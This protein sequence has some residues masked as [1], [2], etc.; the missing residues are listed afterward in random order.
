MGVVQTPTIGLSFPSPKNDGNN[1][2]FFNPTSSVPTKK[3]SPVDVKV[4]ASG[5]GGFPAAEKAFSTR[6]FGEVKKAPFL[7]EIWWSINP[8]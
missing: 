5:F 3:T 4:Q 1:G 8:K 2:T 7:K 6:F